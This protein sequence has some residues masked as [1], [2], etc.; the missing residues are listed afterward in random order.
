MIDVHM[1]NLKWM[2]LLA[3]PLI[4]A[5]EKLSAPQLIYMARHQ[6]A[7]V[8]SKNLNAVVSKNSNAQN[9]IGTKSGRRFLL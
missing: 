4:A 5:A 1:K 6:P 7:R 2:R 3:P 8:L 9:F